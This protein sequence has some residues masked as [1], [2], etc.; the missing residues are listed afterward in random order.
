VEIEIGKTPVRLPQ[1]LYL[2]KPLKR[3]PCQATT[4]SS[5]LEDIAAWHAAGTK[6]G[7]LRNVKESTEYGNQMDI[8]TKLLN[9]FRADG[10][11]KL[12]AERVIRLT[13]NLGLVDQSHREVAKNGVATP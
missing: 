11:P 8:C 13:I 2:S 10:W 1:G 5:D 7:E 4:L 12:D 6:P 3:E 9:R